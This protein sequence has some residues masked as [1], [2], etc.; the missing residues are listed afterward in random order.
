MHL[1]A[2]H[3]SSFDMY[4]ICGL[5]MT[6]GEHAVMAKAPKVCGEFITAVKRKE[7]MLKNVE[8]RIKQLLTHTV[9][10][11]LRSFQKLLETKLPKEALFR[12]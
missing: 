4:H 5:E 6:P 9:K 1:C 12:L 10:G 11:D 2:G 3:L 7:K 8:D